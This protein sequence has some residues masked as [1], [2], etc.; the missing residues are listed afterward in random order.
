MFVAPRPLVISRF[1]G[2]GRTGDES[3]APV[4]VT[5]RMLDALARPGDITVGTNWTIADTHVLAD[6]DPAGNPPM[7]RLSAVDLAT[8]TRMDIPWNR[9]RFG[10][11][12][13]GAAAPQPP[14]ADQ[15]V[16][17]VH[18]GAVELGGNWSGPVRATWYR[19]VAGEIGA[20][21]GLGVVEPAAR[22]VVTVDPDGIAGDTVRPTL[23][24]AINQ[25]EVLSAGLD[26]AD[27][28]PG[29]ADVEIRL[30]TSA[31]LQ[32]PNA[33]VL[34]FAPTLP[35]WRFVAPALLTPTVVGNLT[36]DLID[37]CV[38]VQGFQ[39]T[40]DIRI[41]P[42]VRG[43]ELR[44]LT[45]DPTAGSRL[46]VDPAAWGVEIE[47][48][49]CITGVITADLA[50]RPIRISDSI[51]DGDG[52]ALVMCDAPP[53][54]PVGSVAIAPSGTFPPMLELRGVTV[55][56]TVTADSIDATDCLFV[57][58]LT[59]EQTQVGCIRFSYLADSPDGQ[60]PVTHLCVRA[61]TPT[62]ESRGF[63][64]PGHLALRLDTNAALLAASSTGGAVGADAHA[65][66]AARITRLRRRVAEFVPMG[67]RP[68][69][70][71]AR[72]EAT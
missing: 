51:V 6:F 37:A 22:V 27:S 5:Y 64:S 7:L 11:L 70:A 60:L 32:A 71:I 13:R 21:P 38:S 58:G 16:V 46:V 66:A 9:L 44:E 28:V 62:F 31:R 72:E 34:A 33:P 29:R 67:I 20:L 47:V 56:G 48:D 42:N 4:R 1:V 35:R 63:G 53:A 40:G 49:R 14:N 8:S 36:I 24:Q 23:T 52:V 18:R 12:P 30:M 57:D 61:P 17:D 65:R 69:V 2:S 19:A 25:A 26:P 43:V 3:D 54:P 45:M 59:V 55:A 15:V 10:S 39:V 68:R 50:A 41:G